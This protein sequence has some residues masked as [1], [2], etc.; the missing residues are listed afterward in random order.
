MLEINPFCNRLKRGPVQGFLMDF[1]CMLSMLFVHV[2]TM[3]ASSTIVKP[4]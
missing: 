1:N 4:N 3:S 2:D